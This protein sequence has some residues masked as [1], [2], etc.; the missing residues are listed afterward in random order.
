MSQLISRGHSTLRNRM[1]TSVSSSS[2]AL[3][4]CQWNRQLARSLPYTCRWLSTLERSPT[5]LHPNHHQLH[6][7]CLR[8]ST[9]SIRNPLYAYCLP[10]LTVSRTCTT[11]RSSIV[12]R[13]I[14]VVPQTTESCA[15]PSQAISSPATSFS[16]PTRTCATQTVA[17]TC[18]SATP[19]EH[20]AKPTQSRLEC[21]SE[22]SALSQR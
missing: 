2:Q 12:R 20:K 10:Y 8:Q 22:T 17:S 14:L 1:L 18:G 16:R 3:T 15:N 11:S 4:A 19:V 21:E 5:I 9:A 7:R 13:S 6:R